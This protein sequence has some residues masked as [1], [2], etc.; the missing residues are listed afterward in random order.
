MKYDKTQTKKWNKVETSPLA[1]VYV[2]HVNTCEKH[3][4]F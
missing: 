2:L 4:I 1:S 3:V